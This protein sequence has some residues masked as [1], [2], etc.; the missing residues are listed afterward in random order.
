MAERAGHLKVGRENVAKAIAK[1]DSDHALAVT[2]TLPQHNKLILK[3]ILS[4]SHEPHLFTG[5][6][7]EEYESLAAN[8]SLTPLTLR[9]VSDILNEFDS[10]GLISSKIISRGRYGRTRAVSTKNLHSMKSKLERLL[11]DA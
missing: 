2:K 1:L 3:A 5:D 10:M 9:R 8:S 7:Y 4:R 11:I 6:I